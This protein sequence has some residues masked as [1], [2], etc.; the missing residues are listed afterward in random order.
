MM[1]HH[2]YNI[3]LVALALAPTGTVGHRTNVQSLSHAVL[4]GP[5]HPDE[6]IAPLGH[7]L[8]TGDN[9]RLRGIDPDAPAGLHLSPCV[10]P[11]HVDVKYYQTM[12]IYDVM[13]QAM[14]QLRFTLH[15]GNINATTKI[16]HPTMST[17]SM[18]TNALTNHPQT[19]G[20]PGTNGRTIL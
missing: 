9:I 18:T 8:H 2:D 12:T 5:N 4:V 7:V 19:S 17:T 11:L 1:F 15:R 16:H 13:N 20:N 3:F 14:N 6:L 10:Q